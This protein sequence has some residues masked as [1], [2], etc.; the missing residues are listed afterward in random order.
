MSL[1]QEDREDRIRRRAYELWLDAGLPA[2]GS[3]EFWQEAEDQE[4]AEE[5]NIPTRTGESFPAADTEGRRSPVGQG[6]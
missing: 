3:V 4:V 5:A 6:R 1:R 2:A